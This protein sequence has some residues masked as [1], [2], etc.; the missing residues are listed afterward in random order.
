M[1]MKFRMILITFVNI[2][3]CM[4]KCTNCHAIWNKQFPLSVLSF[5]FVKKRLCFINSRSR[6][7][8]AYALEVG[9]DFRRQ[10]LADVPLCIH[11][12][13]TPWANVLEDDWPQ[14][15]VEANSA[16]D[17]DARTSPCVLLQDVFGS[18]PLVVPSPHSNTSFGLAGAVSTFVHKEDV[19]PLSPVPVQALLRPL[20]SMSC[21]Q[22]WM[23]CWM[24]TTQVLLG[25]L[26]LYGVAT[27]NRCV[28]VANGVLGHFSSR[29]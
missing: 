14:T 2:S 26:L 12:V 16:S 4:F 28:V 18:I 21:C 24:P 23:P 11:A 7:N 22:H 8:S 29:E 25:H 9:H 6:L 1:Q 13:S 10:H 20:L 17:H 19:L 5:K 27:N 15:S 3:F